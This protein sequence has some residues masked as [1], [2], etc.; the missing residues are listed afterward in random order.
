MKS[1]RDWRQLAADAIYRNIS[2]YEGRE[3]IDTLNEIRKMCRNTVEDLKAILSKLEEFQTKLLLADQKIV[4]KEWQKRKVIQNE[5]VLREHP[6][7]VRYIA[8]HRG[9]RR[10]VVKVF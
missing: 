5:S 9:N 2:K 8:G 6:S 7:I 1:Q 4:I 10:P 3:D